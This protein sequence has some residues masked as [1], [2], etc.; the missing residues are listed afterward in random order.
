[1]CLAENIPYVGT[2]LISAN[3][4]CF[5]QSV[6]MLEL[7]YNGLFCIGHL[8]GPSPQSGTPSMQRMHLWIESRYKTS[9]TFNLF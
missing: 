5:S 9:H 4:Q 7:I 3:I 1:M 2:K 6:F 8:L